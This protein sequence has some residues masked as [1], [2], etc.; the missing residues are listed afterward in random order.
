MG[1]GTTGASYR[2]SNRGHFDIWDTVCHL[3]SS[4]TIAE[5][6]DP[7]FQGEE[8]PNPKRVVLPSPLVF[9]KQSMHNG[10]IQQ[11]TCINLPW[12]KV[13]LNHRR[14][15]STQPRPDGCGKRR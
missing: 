15:V 3:E 10:R 14:E 4:P 7:D 2:R 5:F 12:I 11:A 6:P 8:R 9:L 1:Q 13:L